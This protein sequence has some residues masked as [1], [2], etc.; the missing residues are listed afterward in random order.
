MREIITMNKFIQ[1][2]SKLK[3]CDESSGLIISDAFQ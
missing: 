2:D 3:Y 1:K